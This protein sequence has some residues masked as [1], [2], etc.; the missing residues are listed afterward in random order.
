M[1]PTLLRVLAVVEDLMTIGP[2]LP[3]L[4]ANIE[5]IIADVKGSTPPPAT[6]N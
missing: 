6:G 1:N 4:L 3:A 5:K 2:Q